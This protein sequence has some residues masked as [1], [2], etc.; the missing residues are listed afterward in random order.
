MAELLVMN[1]WADPD[2]LGVSLRDGLS[3]EYVVLADAV[4]H[5]Q[6]LDAVVVGPQG[7]FAL[8]IKPWE[9][10]IMR[11][12][13]GA[14]TGHLPSGEQ[15]RYPD[16]APEA[17]RAVQ[18][19]RAFLQDEFPALRPAVYHL[20]VLASP[21]ADVSPA[22]VVEPAFV[23]KSELARTIAATQASPGTGSLAAEER[24]RLAVALRDRRL[25]ASMRASEAFTFRSGA[26]FG[27]G[28]K[29]WTTRAAVEHIDRN[30]ED[31]LFHLQNGTLASWLS[32]QGAEYLAELARQALRGQHDPR[33]A[34][35]AFLTGSGLVS[36]SRP[37]V[38]PRRLRLGPALSGD[39][40]EARLSVRQGRGRGYLFG[41]VRAGEP[42]LHIEPHA[43]SGKPLQAVVSAETEGLAIGQSL[44]QAQLLVESSA[45]AEPLP[46]P[47]QVRVV[48]MPSQLNRTVLRPAAG[49]LVAGLL[50]AAIG[51]ALGAAGTPAPGW[52]DDLL[53]SL[54]SYYSAPAFWAAA[55]G[56][57]WAVMGAVRG[58]WQPP[59]WPVSYATGRW[60]VRTVAWGA[61][62]ALLAAAAHWSWQRLGPGPA[63]GIAAPGLG[64][65]VLSALALAILP[66]T[67]AEIRSG[68]RWN[69]PQ[70][71]QA[72]PGRR[73][74]V[75]RRVVLGALGVMLILVVVVGLPL[76]G[77]AWQQGDVD[78]V[79]SSARPWAV[80]HWTQLETQI[81]E[82]V[83]GILLRSAERR[84]PVHPTTVPTP[85]PAAGG[86]AP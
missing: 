38:R 74:H 28:K 70:A 22:G 20:F 34:V 75:S 43:F 14:W 5:G 11:A 1:G 26:L 8:E 25:T 69:V 7:L 19:V 84:A 39:V 59:A 48:G 3:D 35:E 50:G 37:V 76:L 46:V 61:A 77:R 81:G 42:W 71:A 85:T 9:G 73:R 55:I 86:A 32:A 78:E 15:A 45:T 27:S 16:P 58:L 53:P 31:G 64:A 79:M 65:V 21:G 80:D 18:A 83:D 49:A 68:Q 62:L 60:L 40:C 33:A 66:S 36:R 47:V 4:V 57:L 17:R 24:E 2:S 82:W 63:A 44:W 13:R 72:A 41:A 56:L 67:W 23:S 29:V 54:R 12:R 51:W 6:P 30:P 10:R 52:P